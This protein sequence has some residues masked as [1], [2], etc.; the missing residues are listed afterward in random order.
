MRTID[1]ET[2]R[3]IGLAVTM[4]LLLPIVA[5]GQM[6]Q[7]FAQ[8]QALNAQALRQ[9]TWKSRTEIKKKGETKTVQLALMRYDIDGNIQKT[10]LSSTAQQPGPSRGLRGRIAQKKKE[11]FA[12]LMEDLSNLVKSYS[13]V[14]PDQMQRFMANATIT[15]GAGPQQGLVLIQGK[16][17]LQPGDAMTM[18]VDPTTFMQRKVEIQTALDKKPVRVV[19]EFRDL[20]DGPTYQARSVVSYPS[21]ELELIV[22]NFD[23]EPGK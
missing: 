14:P 13:Q 15:Q 12:D 3:R 7:K 10:P 20:P 8:A 18:W 22:E 23:Y 4:A 1:Y 9:Y 19:S 2:R 6:Q 11:G 16:D 17:L 21:A 5:S